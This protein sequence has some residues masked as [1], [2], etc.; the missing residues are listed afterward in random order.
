VTVRSFLLLSLLG[1]VAMTLLDVIPTARHRGADELPW[2][3][4]GGDSFMKVL[5]IRVEE[6]LWVVLSRFGPGY[7]VQTHKH[8]GQVYAYTIS[9]AW[10]YR[11]S[12]FV[13]RAGSYL[14]EPAGSVHTLYALDDN[15]E[16]TDV[17]F[18]IQGANLNLDAD[19]NVESVTD[20]KSM[21]DGYY[22][23]CEM[24]GLPRPDVLVD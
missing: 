17:F 4:I 10:A 6:G 15:T 24:Q 11:E 2:V 7:T 5:Q 3:D 13:N 8:T 21:L 23:L 16:P 18:A 1:G 22:A 14:F 12:D 20:A 19:G 9:G